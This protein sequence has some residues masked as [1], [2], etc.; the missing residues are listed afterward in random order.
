ME[1]AGDENGFCGVILFMLEFMGN[2]AGNGAYTNLFVKLGGSI[3]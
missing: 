1:I 3:K 2:D